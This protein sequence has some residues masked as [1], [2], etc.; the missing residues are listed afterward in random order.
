MDLKE[1]T[2]EFISNPL[3]RDDLSESPKKAV[4]SLKN[5]RGTNYE[6]YLEVYNELKAA[7]N[8]LWD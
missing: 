1:K 3:K 4:I 8:E 6:T 5:D 2:I 7:Y